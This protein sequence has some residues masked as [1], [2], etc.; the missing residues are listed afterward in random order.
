M[1]KFGFKDL[2]YSI[3]LDGRIKEFKRKKK[4]YRI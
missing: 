1:N 4:F 3:Y 2:K